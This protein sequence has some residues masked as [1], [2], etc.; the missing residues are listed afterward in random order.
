M[1]QI[2]TALKKMQTLVYISDNEGRLKGNFLEIRH[3]SS[4]LSRWHNW[5]HRL[6]QQVDM[7]CFWLQD[8]VGTCHGYNGWVG[9]YLSPFLGL[10]A[11]D[12]K[13]KYQL[14]YHT[15]ILT[16][17]TSDFSLIFESHFFLFECYT[18]MDTFLWCCD[19]ILKFNPFYNVPR[20]LINDHADLKNSCLISPGWWKNYVMEH[21]IQFK[22]LQNLVKVQVSFW[23]FLI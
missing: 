4:S 6:P 19:A 18:S 3:Y 8:M 22:I 5:Q 23:M 7:F 14:W 1:D 2:S 16:N 21:A 9:F 12:T 10:F 15:H 20:N 11:F 17:M 13:L